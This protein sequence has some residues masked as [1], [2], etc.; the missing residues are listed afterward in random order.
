MKGVEKNKKVEF[1]SLDYKSS[2]SIKIGEFI[3]VVLAACLVTIVNNKGFVNIYTLLLRNNLFFVILYFLIKISYVRSIS[4]KENKI[5]IK[6][7]LGISEYSYNELELRIFKDL[8]RPM[9]EKIILKNNKKKFVLR[10]IDW[11]DYDKIIK[12]LRKKI[13]N[14]YE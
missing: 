1:Y 2:Y 13:K 3:I 7:L 4:L 6:T 12:F 14:I 5:K 9:Q 8:L 11:P 10:I